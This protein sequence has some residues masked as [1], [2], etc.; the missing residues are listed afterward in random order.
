MK[1]KIIIIGGGIAG[2]TSAHELLN[3]NYDI[4]LI[5]RNDI[6]GGLARTY[7]NEENKICPYE[8]SW[9][10]YGKW[11]QNVFD[12]MKKI[13]FNNKEKVFNQLTNLE[14][15]KK[16]CDKKIPKHNDI[17]NNPNMNDKMKIIPIIL[18]YALSCNE[19]N[20]ENFSHVKLIDLINELNLSKEAEDT[21]GKIVGPYLGFD[22][23]FASVYD[24]LYFFEMY[25]YNINNSYN[26]SIT[27][28][29]TNYA[30]FDPWKKFLIKNGVTILNNTTVQKL[31]IKNSKIQNIQVKTKNKKPYNLKGDY[32]INCTGPEILEKFLRPYKKVYPKYWKKI[33][34]VKNNGYQI[35]LSI[36]YYL[37]RKIFLA[38]EN[39]LAY[40][41]NTPWLLM[42]LPTGHIW[43]DKYLNK[44]C[45][46]NIKEVI[47]V[48]I[49]E[50]YVKGN[51][52]KKPWSK[53]TRKEIEIEAWNQLINDKDFSQNICIDKGKSINDI[54]IIDFK[55]WDSYKFNKNGIKTFE[56]KWANNVKTIENR[57]LSNTP[58]SNLIVGGS[59]TNTSTGCFSMESACE[60][61]K[62]AAIKL[63]DLDQKKNKIYLY[64]KKKNPYTEHLRSL[65]CKNYKQGKP[66]KIYDL[67]SLSYHNLPTKLNNIFLSYLNEYTIQN[68]INNF[69]KSIS[70]KSNKTF[71]NTFKKMLSK[72]NKIKTTRKT[73]KS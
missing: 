38:N 47:S 3:K 67:S 41:P 23:H 14:G 2:M 39:T 30:W 49:C 10:A 51:L 71:K 52:I 33:N 4:I 48:G 27:K 22:Y 24:T 36:Y 9:R 32:Y 58:I 60:S 44:Y 56:P 63:C 29:P 53:C 7:Q 64:T 72:K 18:N 20:I 42:V 65:D 25:L 8:Y 15:G 37:D 50:P 26:F 17:M 43:G 54:K 12:V 62:I 1:K 19:R 21:I 40:L 55:M 34:N 6:L 35:Q 28:Y 5:E 46:K 73:K 45:K 16:T 11:Y 59:Y 13:P 70:N 69:V 57:P 61:G 68:S 66:Q 31:N